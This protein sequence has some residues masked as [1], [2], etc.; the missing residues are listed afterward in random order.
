MI[1]LTMKNAL[2]ILLMIA[3]LSACT[4]S[5][6]IL[7]DDNVPE[8][9]FYLPDEV[10]PF[11]GQCII[12][13]AGT[14]SVKERMTFKKGILDGT[15]TSYYPNGE[16]KV[17]GEYKSGKLHGKWE[18]WYAGG[19]KKFEVNYVNDT[20]TGNYVMWY[21][22]GVMKEKGLYAENMRFGAWVEYDEAGM[23]VK[24]LKFE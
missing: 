15:T 16:V 21:D 10:R 18:S 23:I 3:G 24:K 20:L 7:T 2:Y 11:T 13:Y 9:T 19:K 12:Y 4:N 5:K 22:T 17:R 1:L 14:E 8:D 6:V